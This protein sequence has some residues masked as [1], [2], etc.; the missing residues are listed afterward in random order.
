MKAKTYYDEVGRYLDNAKE[1]LS[2]T[3]IIDGFYEDEKYVK[4]AGGIAYAGLEKAARWYLKLNGYKQPLKNY[5]AIINGLAKYN[6]KAQKLFHD[7]Y[8]LLY[9]DAY[10]QDVTGVDVIKA[11]LSYVSKF[12]EFL[13]P[14][15]GSNIPEKQSP[16]KQRGFRK[17]KTL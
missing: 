1:C 7:G 10:Y 2:K 16:I 12:S 9:I 4:Q 11:G 8:A 3:K 17:N 5:D 14:F 6:H 15:N 13:K